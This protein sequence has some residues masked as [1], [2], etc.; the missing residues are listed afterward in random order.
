MDSSCVL[1]RFP[2]FAQHA[3][4]LMLEYKDGSCSRAVWC[5][6]VCCLFRHQAWSC[7]L[8]PDIPSRFATSGVVTHAELCVVSTR[9][10]H[11]AV[12]SRPRFEKLLVLLL[13]TLTSRLLWMHAE[14]AVNMCVH[15]LCCTM[16]CATQSSF[17][18][19]ASVQGMHGVLQTGALCCSPS[20]EVCWFVVLHTCTHHLHEACHSATQPKST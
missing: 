18:C 11:F 8:L 14:P 4:V 6:S 2:L 7:Q 20:M 17:K 3:A 10:G 12:G 13:L 1:I 15:I 19:I 5:S 9:A 16:Q